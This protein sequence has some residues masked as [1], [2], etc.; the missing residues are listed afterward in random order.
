MRERGAVRDREQVD[1]RVAERR[2]DLVE[3]VGHRDGGVLAKI[4]I[5]VVGLDAAGEPREVERCAEHFG[6]VFWIF[7][8]ALQRARATGATHVDEHEIA[9]AEDR[10]ELVHD[11]RRERGR[12]L[13]GTAGEQEHR[14]ALGVREVESRHRDRELHRATVGSFAILLDLEHT[15]LELSDA[16]ATVFQLD[17]GLGRRIATRS[18]GK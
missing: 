3:I 11:H 5:V 9:L 13:P 6:E 17:R 1:L 18:A 15:A 12:A 2:A 14:I 8:V 10:V 7:D 16:S 4:E